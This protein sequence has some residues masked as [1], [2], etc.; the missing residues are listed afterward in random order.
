M[1][2]RT[3]RGG[4]GGR[5]GAPRDILN[6]RD[7]QGTK[8]FT[9]EDSD[10]EKIRTKKFQDLLNRLGESGLGGRRK[11]PRPNRGSDPR[12]RPRV[13]RDPKDRPR[14]PRDPK[15]RPRVP[16]R[17]SGP[18]DK[19]DPVEE[20]KRR[21]QERRRERMLR[22]E[23]LKRIRRERREKRRSRRNKREIR[24]PRDPNRPRIPRDRPRVPKR[25]GERG[26]K[27]TPRRGVTGLPNERRIVSR[28]R[29]NR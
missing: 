25:R 10:E 13:P 14:V 21:R 9:P 18:A 26:P 27:P 29:R 2:S 8:V 12:N 3:P 23:K 24:V 5:G 16:N 1:G 20:R 19:G 11:K 7:E 28:D 22:R 17:G 15:D 6:V 4:R